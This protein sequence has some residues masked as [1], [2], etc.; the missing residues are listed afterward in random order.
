MGNG[1]VWSSLDPNFTPA[2][3]VLATWRL[4]SS[5]STQK[6]GTLSGNSGSYAA[7]GN[8]GKYGKEIW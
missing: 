7:S 2:G 1:D 4:N 3:T 6:L 5:A 8:T